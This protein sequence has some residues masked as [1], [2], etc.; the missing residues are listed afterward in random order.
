MCP[1][2]AEPRI[3]MVTLRRF[4]SAQYDW[5]GIAPRLLRSKAWYIGSLIAAAVV[6]LL[7]I[8][9][10]HLWYVGLHVSDLAT[11]L[12]LEHM[13]P[14]MTYYTLTVMI[15][16]LL[17]LFTRVIRIWRLT[18]SDGEQRSITVSDYVREAWVYAYESVTESLMH[19]CPEHR[20]WFPHFMLA[21]GTMLM[22]SIK[23]FGLRWFQTDSIYALYHP[24]RLL[25]YVGSGLILYGI[26]DILIGRMLARREI[27]KETRFQDLVLPILLLLTVISGLAI[28]I[29]RLGGFAL[30]C[31]FVYAVHIMVTTPMLVVEMAFG[32]WAHMIYR[33]LALYF[34]AVKQRAAERAPAEEGIGY[35]F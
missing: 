24:Q 19:K 34:H 20:R 2:Q 4:L 23:L 5:T 27:Y 6:T 31:H 21:L 18:M 12:G 3:S 26:G 22:L 1:R 14:L 33:P 15:V 11:P 17:L 7:L 32:K 35:A 13:F 30:T 28:H 16:P 10:Y 9:S 25:G 8:L 29:F